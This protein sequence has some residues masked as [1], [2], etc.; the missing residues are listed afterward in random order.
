MIYVMSDIHG[1]YDKFIKMLD[2]IKFS[3]NDKLYILGDVFDRGERPLDI[4]DYIRKPENSNIE[5]LLGNHEDFYLRVINDESNLPLWLHNGGRTT[6]KQLNEKDGAYLVELVDYLENLPLYKIIDNFILVHAGIRIPD[7]TDNL[8]LN[9]ILS[10]QDKDSLLWERD[11]VIS[12]KQIK[13]YTV[14]CG[15]TPTINKEDF[16][17]KADIKHLN[18]KIMIDCGAYFKE[19][20]GRLACLRLDDL[21]EFYID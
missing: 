3:S 9:T 12:N 5:M 1:E 13:N 17:N 15:H 16:T 10:N 8:D 20:N 6:L 2:L 18:G 21:Q 4:I 7:N 11:F 14:I 19:F